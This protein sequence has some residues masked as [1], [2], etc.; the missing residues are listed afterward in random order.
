M[1]RY[2]PCRRLGGDK[3]QLL[4][5]DHANRWGMSVKHHALAALYPRH[6][7]WTGGWVGTRAGLASRDCRGSNPIR[8]VR[9]ARHFTKLPRLLAYL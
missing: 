5:L 6:T 9:V 3:V 7:H 2:T 4:I 1:S 8:L